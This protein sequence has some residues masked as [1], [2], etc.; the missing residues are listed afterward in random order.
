MV[1]TFDGVNQVI[2][3]IQ[4]PSCHEEGFRATVNSSVPTAALEKREGRQPLGE[5]FNARE[6]T[7]L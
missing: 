4:R 5:L 1:G 7:L 3:S 2:L 6:N